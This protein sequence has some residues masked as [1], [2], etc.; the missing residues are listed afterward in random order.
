ME[1]LV[2]EVDK[3]PP[4]SG[5]IATP[6]PSAHSDGGGDNVACLTA[7]QCNARRQ[8]LGMAGFHQADYDIPSKGC[9]SKGGRVYFGIGGSK[10]DMTTPDLP[11][12]RERLWCNQED[13][14]KVVT[15]ANQSGASKV[16][17]ITALIVILLGF[18]GS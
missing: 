2:S 18:A 9:F 4:P 15:Q 6:F 11:G 3:A 13:D 14:V 8:Q 10:H 16:E 17:G 5:E 1:E 12:K 7:K